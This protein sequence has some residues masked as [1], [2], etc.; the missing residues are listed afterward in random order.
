MFSINNDCQHKGGMPGDPRLHASED[1]EVCA[2]D[3]AGRV[4][5]GVAGCGFVS[6]DAIGRFIEAVRLHVPGTVFRFSR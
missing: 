5:S 4:I 1:A 6:P 2:Y 3:A